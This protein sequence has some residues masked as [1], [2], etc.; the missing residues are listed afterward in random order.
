MHQVRI[1]ELAIWSTQL[2]GRVASGLPDPLSRA[3][4]RAPLH[5]GARPLPQPR[6][7]AAA[8]GRLTIRVL[9]RVLNKTSMADQQLQVMGRASQEMLATCVAHMQMRSQTCGSR[10]LK[11]GRLL[12]RRS[13]N[14]STGIETQGPHE[15]ELPGVGQTGNAIRE[16][17]PSPS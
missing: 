15:T 1:P 9:E 7:A 14:P 3:G 5:P 11:V 8:A 17:R 10:L 16:E 12:F 6:V 13:K 4:R 2:R